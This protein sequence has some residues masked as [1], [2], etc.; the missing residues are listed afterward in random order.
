MGNK[1]DLTFKSYDDTVLINEKLIKEVSST[2]IL[3]ELRHLNM[4]IDNLSKIILNDE[5]SHMLSENDKFKIMK[6]LSHVLPSLSNLT[7]KLGYNT[8]SLAILSLTDKL[9]KDTI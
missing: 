4:I 2:T 7:H 8:E 9:N 5:C 3:K 6:Q 1:K